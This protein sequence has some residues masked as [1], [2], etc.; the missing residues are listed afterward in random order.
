MKY[1]VFYPT[2]IS[3]LTDIY[4]DSIDVC[5][6]LENG[7]AYTLVF[8]TPKNLENLMQKENIP[9]IDPCFRF[10]V[11][12]RISEDVIETVLRNLISDKHLLREYGL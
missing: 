10:I 6:T 3:E 5:I 4:N 8:I 9:Y 11:I 1:T 2:K 12:E 7:E